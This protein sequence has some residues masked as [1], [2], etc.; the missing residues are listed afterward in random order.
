MAYEISFDG[1]LLVIS[2]WGTLSAAE[3]DAIVDDVLALEQ[4][5]TN[6]PNR[7]IDLRDV[8]DATV[9]Y[10][11]VAHIASRSRVRPLA[12]RLRSA[13]LVAQPVQFGYAR[14]FQML[15]DHPQVTISIFD[16]EAS[17]RGWL[18]S[19]STATHDI[20]DDVGRL[21][22]ELPMGDVQ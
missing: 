18:V 3:L 6:T 11:E 9:G 20:T 8:S 2:L 13:I 19:G 14:M 10:V 21:T 7:L 17:A 15:N 1:P 16:D 12:R 22:D 5:G 4:G